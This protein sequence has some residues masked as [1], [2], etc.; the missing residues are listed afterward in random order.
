[1][2]ISLEGALSTHARAL[3]LRGERTR[4]IAQNIANAD[5][6]GFRA[7]DLDFAAHMR[8]DAP[9]AARPTAT[10]PRH[11]GAG[12]GLALELGYRRPLQPSLDQ[13]TVE[14]PVEQA[15]FMENSVKYLATLS[16]MNA[17]VQGLLTAITGQ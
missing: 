17:K 5:T 14:T 6:P 7:R 2:A 3:V 9:G 15:A 1:M 4:I 11:F 13:N 10:H 12:E 16:L 8:G